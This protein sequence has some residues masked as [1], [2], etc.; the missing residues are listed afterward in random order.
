[1]DGLC[2]AYTVTYISSGI[3]DFIKSCFKQREKA[4]VITAKDAEF[5][6]KKQLESEL[7]EKDSVISS[8]DK[9]LTSKEELISVMVSEIAEKDG[10]L[11][12]LQERCGSLQTQL[13]TVQSRMQALEVTHNH[14]LCAILITYPNYV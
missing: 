12:S 11:A 9:Q 14:K 3:S 5:A 4:D 1:M 8:K 2:N 6:A 10:G 13:Q 7:A